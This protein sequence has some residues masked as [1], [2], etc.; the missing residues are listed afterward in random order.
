MCKCSFIEKKLTVLGVI[1]VSITAL[2]ITLAIIMHVRVYVQCAINRIGRDKNK[3][4]ELIYMY[5]ESCVSILHAP[6]LGCKEYI[7]SLLRTPVRV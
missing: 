3:L 7:V 5:K 1:N 6:V 4:W 2:Y